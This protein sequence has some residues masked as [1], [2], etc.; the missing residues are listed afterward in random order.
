MSNNYELLSQLEVADRFFPGTCDSPSEPIIDSQVVENSRLPSSY[1]EAFNL[2][3][4]VFLVN[5]DLA[6]HVV[7]FTSPQ[8]GVGC[9]WVCTRISE[10]LA[11]RLPGSVCVVD[12]NLH[13]PALHRYF[14]LDNRRGLTQALAESNPILDYVQP[15]RSRRVSVLTTGCSSGQLTA[16][17]SDRLIQRLTE[18]RQRFSFLLIDAPAMNLYADVT[19]L[20][21]VTDGAILVLEADS[22]R[23]EAAVQ[24]RDALAAA[25]FRLLGAALNKRSFPIPEFVYRRL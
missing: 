2:V 24:A 1:S 13:S 5:P 20:S 18:L 11:T 19:L 22:T 14:R 15:V 9:S 6:P 8:R 21:S 4:R 25:K 16:W 7:V 23:R 17:A 10:T 3:Q 12:A